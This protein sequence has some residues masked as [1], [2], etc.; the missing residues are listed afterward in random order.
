MPDQKTPQPKGTAR[1]ADRKKPVTLD[2]VWEEALGRI[3]EKNQVSPEELQNTGG[4]FSDA[5]HGLKT[6]MK[7]F[8]H[9]RQP[10]DRKNK[11]LTSVAGCLDWVHSGVTFV[12]EHV[13]GTYAVPVKLVAGSILYM[14]QAAEDIT[15]DFN[16]IESTFETLHIAL[17]DIGDLKGRLLDKSNFLHRLT[18]IFIAMVDFCTFSG[19]V[20]TESSRKRRYL[21]A[22]MKGRNKEIKAKCDEVEKVIRVFRATL[23]FQA[24]NVLADMGEKMGNLSTQFIQDLRDM[25][26]K[27]SDLQPLWG[28]PNSLDEIR[29]RLKESK[30]LDPDTEVRVETQMLLIKK[31]LVPDTFSW[32]EK[33]SIYKLWA[34]GHRNPFI[35]VSGKAGTG[36]TFFAYH[37]YSTIQEKSVRATND[38]SPEQRRTIL[39]TYFPFQP[40]RQDS[41]SFRNVLAYILVQVA[42]HDMK[43]C[44]SIAKDLTTSKTYKSG[45]NAEK[46]RLK[47]LWNNLLVKKFEKTPETSR[48]VFIVLDGIELMEESDRNAM[49]ELF[50]TL[51]SDKCGIRVLMTATTDVSVYNTVFE[52]TKCLV[53]DL[54]PKTKEG[55]DF[56]KIIDARIDGSETLS[57]FNDTTKNAIKQKLLNRGH[58]LSSVDL[59]LTMMEQEETQDSAEGKIDDV[60]SQEGLYS[61]MIKIVRSKR[62]EMDCRIVETIFALCTYAKQPLTL[63]ELQQFIDQEP[64]FGSFDVASEIE[65]RSSSLLY[66]INYRP[67]D[68]QTRAMDREG[69]PDD[70]VATAARLEKKMNDTKQQ[71][72]LF[73]QPAF[74]D[75]L[76]QS[77][78]NMIPRPIESRVFFFLRLAGILCDRNPQGI[79]L[80]GALQPVKDTNPKHG[81]QIVEALA[82]VLSNEN[83][84][85]RVFEELHG[86]QHHGRGLRFDLYNMSTESDWMNR[87]GSENLKLLKAWARKMSFHDEVG[88]SERAK[89]WVEKM[90]ME[91]GSVLERLARG[92]IESWTEKRTHIEAEALYNLICCA[93][94]PTGNFSDDRLFLSRYYP[95]VTASNVKHILD[96]SQTV[97]AT[98]PIK[99]ARCRIAAGLVL[100]FSSGETENTDLAAELYQTNLNEKTTPGP[101]RFYSYLGLAENHGMKYAKSES[102][103]AQETRAG[104]KQVVKYADLALTARAEEKGALGSE[105]ADERCT[106]AFF[107]KADALKRLGED[108]PA[109]DTCEEALQEGLEYTDQTLKLLTIIVDLHAKNGAWNRVIDAVSR[110]PLKLRSEWLWGRSNIFTNEEDVFRRAA[111]ETRRVDFLV[112]TFHDAVDYWQKLHPF[113]ALVTKFELA[114]IYRRDVR[115]TRMAEHILDTLLAKV[116]ESQ[117]TMSLM[118]FI[119]P[120]LVDIHHENFM[121]TGSCTRYKMVPN[122][123]PTNLAGALL[124]LAKMYYE[125]KD[126]AQARSH[127]DRAFNICIADLEDSIGSNDQSAFRLLGKIALSLQLA[128]VD[129]SY[130]DYADASWDKDG[131]PSEPAEEV[132]QTKQGQR[133]DA[134]NQPDKEW[135]ETKFTAGEKETDKPPVTDGN[136][137]ELPDI[138]P[139]QDIIDDGA[140]SCD[141]P[142]VNPRFQLKVFGPQSPKMYFC[143]D[144]ADVDLCQECY[145]KQIDFYDRMGSG[146]WFKCCWSRHQYLELPI[147][148]WM[149]VKD[150]VIRVGRKDKLW[151]DW[152]MSVKDR[153]KRKIGEDG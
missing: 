21:R 109:I 150:G 24:L 62:S 65:G 92:H 110:Q 70:L 133:T 106:N 131:Q 143:L 112:Q 66:T 152:L 15:E 101:E 153:W 5:E 42:D 1:P 84:V 69:Q 37:C 79:K 80:R 67:A 36:K 25:K 121:V 14:I 145:Q 19:R 100:Q 140:V 16:L 46:E 125:V 151:K 30:D 120:E 51:N 56:E 86:K 102:Q 47:F 96:Y 148:D 138:S 73:R 39:A 128:V 132:T 113:R 26:I 147:D 9:S 117:N 29:K 34:T 88:L 33:D 119:F 146:F 99:T 126:Q 87:Q 104:W 71:Q 76:E 4:Q 135:S 53:I 114:F 48:E 57:L 49:L 90:I 61:A 68:T 93:L 136:H 83:D 60:N 63:Y 27:S 129:R 59:T 17:Q 77:K 6:A 40:G 103:E 107:L 31:H 105:L 54:L 72:V 38:Q 8:K 2:E 130:D 108:E 11:V 122:L 89:S 144:C 78:N 10:T 35:Y 13:S 91:P 74:R 115:A 28:K 141:G 139:S 44:E 97:M 94:Q 116:T 118:G 149:G 3:T 32:A 85:C 142:C 45:N 58:V 20:F 55:G 7:F 23:P 75:Y 95:V 41:Q 111:V 98:T 64:T 18:D 43:L 12:K 137:I 124:V 52:F 82:R 134:A 50:Q 81:L 22:L 127:A 123:E